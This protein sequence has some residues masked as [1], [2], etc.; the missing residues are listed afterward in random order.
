MK[1]ELID[2]A[3]KSLEALIAD[4]L[5]SGRRDRFYSIQKLAIQAEHLNR[6]AVRRIDDAIDAEIGDGPDQLIE[7]DNGNAMYMPRRV[8]RGGGM[9]MGGDQGD[10]MRQIVGM[11]Q[12]TADK[13]AKDM[14][15]NARQARLDRV[16]SLLRIR[17]KMVKQKMD[18]SALDLQLKAAQAAVENEHAV[19]DSELL[20]GRAVEGAVE[21]QD[22][23]HGRQGDAIGDGGPEGAPDLRGEEGLEAEGLGYRRGI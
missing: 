8:I 15:A 2:S 3:V 10:M 5:A 14:E 23:D 17:D 16:E 22:A 4:E 1:N 7:Y 20:R 12:P 6:M 9:V 19:D 11:M 18:V 13:A 21:G